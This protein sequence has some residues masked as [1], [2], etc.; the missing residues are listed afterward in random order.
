[1]ENKEIFYVYADYTKEENPRIFYVGK[2]KMG[3]VEDYK[4]SRRNPV[5]N[6]ISKKYGLERKIIFE[7]HDEKEALKVEIQ[8]ILEHKTFVY[9]ED[10]VWGANLTPGG[11]GVTGCRHNEESKRKIS[12]GLNG[13]KSWNKG[14]KNCFSDEA[15]KKISD[16]NKGKRRSE[17]TKEKIRKIHLG[18]KMSE[19]SKKKM[20]DAKLGTKLTDDHKRKIGQA[21]KGKKRSQAPRKKMSESAGNKPV[22]QL[23]MDGII[24]N[25]FNSITEAALS[26]GA[27]NIGVCCRGVRKTSGGFIWKFKDSES[28]NL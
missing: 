26:T 19:E 7:T 2:G 24:L 17:E 22:E 20:R 25:T 5:H 13:R 3:R 10:Y 9:S 8:K 28:N 6:R 23:S 14:T 11:D 18:K 16:K 12:E 27:L 4:G 15:R 1:M 21:G